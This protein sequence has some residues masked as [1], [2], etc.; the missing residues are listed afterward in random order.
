MKRNLSKLLCTAMALIMF[1][2][3][4]IVYISANSLEFDIS[5]QN[6]VEQ[7]GD[8]S[9]KIFKMDINNDIELKNSMIPYI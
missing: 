8:I 4:N 7:F 3:P 9:N 1:F 6:E 5:L 2:T